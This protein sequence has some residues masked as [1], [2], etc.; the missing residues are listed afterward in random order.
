ME[1]HKPQTLVV[2]GASGRLGRLV[3]HEL[4]QKGGNDK[5][6]AITRNPNRLAAF[7][8]Q[9]VTVLK[10]DFND[11]NSLDQ[12]FQQADR[13]LLISTNVVENPGL[14]IT[15]HRNA[16]E[17]AARS[18][19]KHVTY[20][21]FSNPA[22]DSPMTSPFDHFATEQM[23]TAT[24]LNWTILRNNIYADMI[25]QRFPF[26]FA[27]GLLIGAAGKGGVS[28]IT[29]EDCAKAAAAALSSR[30]LHNT[31]FDIAGSQI[32]N[33]EELSKII[34]AFSGQKI[35]YIEVTPEALRKHLLENNLSKLYAD[36]FVSCDIAISQRL[37]EID[38][39]DFKK[40]TGKEPE[41]LSDFLLRNRVPMRI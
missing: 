8:N 10:A 19:I 3:L 40:L 13:L 26:V 37:F 16:I 7:A 28:Y 27:T 4:I 24:S 11:P 17:A 18:N 9:G 41:I 6:I 20:T 23:L 12:A 35:S 32:I 22:P 15:L 25:F 1:K 38:S 29:R 21:S 39:N 33:Y 30:K 36:L 34:T 14:R 31:T 2:S 5:I